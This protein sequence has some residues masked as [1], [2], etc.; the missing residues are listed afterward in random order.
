MADDASLWRRIP[1]DKARRY[2]NVETGQVISRT[3]YDKRYGRLA[4]QGFSHP[5][6]QAAANA[7]KDRAAQLARPAPG[8]IVKPDKAAATLKPIKNKMGRYLHMPFRIFL[9]DDEEE[10]LIQ[11][12]QY[13]SEYDSIIAGV[14]KNKNFDWVMFE[15]QV[16]GKHPV[17]IKGPLGISYQVLKDSLPDF[18]TFVHIL[19]LEAEKNGSL[20]LNLWTE[21][22]IFYLHTEKSKRVFDDKL[23]V[24]KKRK[25]KIQYFAKKKTKARKKKARK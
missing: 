9:T 1:G 16:E 5:R 14:I 23:Y 2:A 11:A 24:L 7:R 4:R 3:V 22:I 10:N 12:Y 13:K 21:R 18:D 20:G 17:P 19:Y 25:N 6:Q 15:V 8:R